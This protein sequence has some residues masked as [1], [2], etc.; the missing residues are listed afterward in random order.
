MFVSNDLI[1]NLSYFLPTNEEVLFLTK[2]ANLTSHILSD[3][4]LK[5][6]L[7]FAYSIPYEIVNTMSSY[8]IS[9]KSIY[10]Y[11]VKYDMGFIENM[12]IPKSLY[13][14]IL[15]LSPLHKKDLSVI[16]NSDCLADDDVNLLKFVLTELLKFFDEENVILFLNTH[17]FMCGP[18]ILQFLENR[19]N[20]D[21]NNLSRDITNSYKNFSKHLN[22]ICNLKLIQLDTQLSLW[23][24]KINFN[25]ASYLH[26]A[27]DKKEID[28]FPEF[29]LSRL[30]SFTKIRYLNNILYDNVAKPSNN[31]IDYSDIL[32]Y[33]RVRF[34]FGKSQQALH[35]FGFGNVFCDNKTIGNYLNLTAEPDADNNT[36][37]VSSI[38][39]GIARGLNSILGP[40]VVG[41]NSGPIAVGV[42]SGP[43]A[44]GVNSGPVA[45]GVNSG[46]VAVGVNAV[47]VTAPVAVGVNAG[48]VTAPI[49]V[50]VNAGPVTAP[51][52]VGQPGI[53]GPTGPTG[54]TGAT[55]PSGPPLEII[56]NSPLS[57]GKSTPQKFHNIYGCTSC[58][59][60][61]VD[62]D[63][64]YRTVCFIEAIGIVTTG[65]YSITGI[66]PVYSISEYK[67]IIITIRK[68]SI[69]I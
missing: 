2:L 11:I 69:L 66:D 24:Y 17:I 12:F 54:A 5:Q 43:V 27:N 8:G 68:L 30:G 34:T 42:N 4:Y 14:V 39:T 33:S 63:S 32:R 7:F 40:V 46:P 10:Y 16:Y 37:Y 3:Y 45:V 19:F 22:N 13:K 15:N 67:N 9:M 41:V 1:V 61:D 59:L 35:T 26:F 18:N 62:F 31:Y 38:A 47:P 58:V 28:I 23:D 21:K 56:P 25:N 52:A 29:Y 20:L 55:G 6:R 49:A 64:L 51:I 36:I 48:P 65:D 57:S 50:G 53:R 60:P 44:V